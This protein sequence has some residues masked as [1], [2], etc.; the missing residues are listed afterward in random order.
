MS[1]LVRGFLLT[2]RKPLVANIVCDE[3]EKCI[4]IETVFKVILPSL[5]LSSVQSLMYVCLLLVWQE[6]ATSK[7][8]FQFMNK[9]S[10]MT[11][12]RARLCRVERTILREL[13]SHPH[14]Q[15]C[16]LMLNLIQSWT[17][18]RSTAFGV[19]KAPTP[20][21]LRHDFLPRTT[22][23]NYATRGY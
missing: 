23:P 18:D 5:L 6:V 14:L 22:T 4:S 13:G 2:G 12:S 21:Q 8:N 15:T 10:H 17:V 16:V 9:V 19:I 20:H 1:L 3:E 7:S 11:I